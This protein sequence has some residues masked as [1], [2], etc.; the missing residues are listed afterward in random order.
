MVDPDA[1][2]VVEIEADIF[3]A[4]V[5]AGAAAIIG[6]PLDPDDGRQNVGVGIESDAAEFFEECV[7][8]LFIDGLR[9]IVQVDYRVG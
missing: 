5:G 7:A 3:L 2:A 9:Q 1:I 6:L 8:D 4:A